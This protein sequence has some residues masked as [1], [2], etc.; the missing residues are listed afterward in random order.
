MVIT[1][2]DLFLVQRLSEFIGDDEIGKGEKIMN[3]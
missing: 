2:V 3:N 1:F